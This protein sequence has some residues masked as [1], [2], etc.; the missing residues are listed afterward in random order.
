MKRLVMFLLLLVAPV[1]YG[2]ANSSVTYY[3]QLVQGSDSESP[4]FPQAHAIGKKLSQRLHN[5]FR[6][7][8]YW[9]IKRENLN[10][11]AGGK[12]RQA[13]MPGREVEIAWHSPD[14]VT[15]SILAHGKITRKRTQSIDTAFYIAGG[16]EDAGQPWFIIIRRDNPDNAQVAAMP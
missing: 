16:D 5:V 14:S 3:I 15:I 9:E 6:W 2:A 7:K 4:P 10:L 11:V 13:I 8:N 12:A 1:A